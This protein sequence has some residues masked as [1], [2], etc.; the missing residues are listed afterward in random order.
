MLPV[1]QLDNK[2]LYT[3]PNILSQV[4]PG[5]MTV[6]QNLI[7]DR[8]GIGETRRGFD[9]YGTPL[10][11]A[12]VKAYVYMSRLLWYC[13][14]G[15]LVY[16]SDGAG[17]WATYTGLFSPPT[18]SFINST[19]SNGNFYFTTNNGIYK[20]DALTGTP[21]KAG[22]P[23][24]LDLSATL[25]TSGTGSA[26]VTGSQVA[27]AIVWGYL[28]ANNNLVLGAPTEWAFVIN[29][30]GSTQDNTIVTTIPEEVG[31]GYFVQVYRTPCTSSASIVPGNTFQ[32]ATQYSP[33]LTDITNK[34][35]TIID[36]TPD[37]LLGAYLYTA[38]GQPSNLP[39]TSPPLALDITTFNAMTFYIN[40][41]TAQ[42]AT[43]TLASAGAPNGI[44][45]N[46]TFTITDQNTLAAH[47][48][49][50]K[51]ANNFP[52]R[53]FAV[54]TGG[55]IASNIDK[56]ARNL[57]A[58]INQDPLNTLWYAYYQTG[59]NVLPGGIILKARNLQTG[60][61]YF[62]SS[63]TT[64]WTP[65]ISSTGSLYISNN[66]LSPNSFIVS[67]VAQPE[68]VPV[69]YTFP[70][71]SGNI[72][73]ELYRGL[74]LQDALYLFSNAGVFRVTGTDPTTLQ[75]ILF[76]SSANLVGLQTPTILNNS[77]YYYSTQGICSV[78][79]G[80][81]QIV[82]RN[83]E[84]DIIQLS[85][86]SNFSSLA[87]GC[88]YESDR[89]YI[90]FAPSSGADSCATQQYVY[91]W[92]TTAFT[93]WDRSAPAAIVN[94]ETNK[95]YMADSEGN[96]FQERKTFSN[97][98][99]ADEARAITINTIDS[100]NKIFTLA[101]S[102]NVSV[103]DIIQKTVS[104]TQYSTQVT[105]NNTTT[106]EVGVSTVTGFTTGSATDYRSIMTKIRFAPITCGFANHLK[107]V[108]NWKFAFSNA[109][110]S[111]I[112]A[113]FTS[114][115]YQTPETATLSPQTVGGW[116]TE[117]TG[118]GTVPWGVSLIAEQVIPC[119]PTKNTA[120]ARWW[121]IDLNLTQA[122]TSLALD[123]LM[124][125]FDIVSIRGR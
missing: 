64:C 72:S 102:T 50:A 116:G 33:N 89:K 66:T 49:T 81:N 125:S 6:A 25:G 91:N 20:L 70:V 17:T 28:D 108:A 123:G 98:D 63:R 75:V 82:S 36:A 110:F 96:I 73:V 34:Y 46:D 55:T 39:N 53:Q 15:Q 115:I 88:G 45:V 56:T 124:C 60:A 7:I 93:L 37:S 1:V 119:N 78:S 68:A 92:I 26:Q 19:Q 122:F 32:L 113:S 40:F 67:K 22:A 100:T 5:A 118:W 65:T 104:G 11:S 2:G 48:Y 4:P 74:A 29:S 80:G 35:V 76:D 62:N 24:G 57:A 12:A 43:F 77:I 59:T 8:P 121:I 13:T 106:G 52:L 83:V 58:A 9:F 30:S 79:S 99:Y 85:V 54:V 105:S 71:Q 112:A 84:R 97:A 14:G 31:L 10:P 44:Q 120:Y 51:S 109:N 90:L 95:L 3:Y 114:D 107:R 42:Q 18:N 103:G 61:F 23:E 41:S 117:P 16:D 38:D 27:Y 87:F 94:P 86:L 21:K 101:D 111:S 69:A 47:I